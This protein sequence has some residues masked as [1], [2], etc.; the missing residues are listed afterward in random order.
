MDKEKTK[1]EKQWEQLKRG[2]IAELC[3]AEAPASWVMII[4]HKGPR[5]LVFYPWLSVLRTPPSL[6][7]GLSITKHICIDTALT[8]ILTLTLEQGPPRKD[9]QEHL[10]L[11]VP[12]KPGYAD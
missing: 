11:P 7:T 8:E 2:W 5:Q 6:Q 4:M 12:G 3:I 9:H 1:R 10:L